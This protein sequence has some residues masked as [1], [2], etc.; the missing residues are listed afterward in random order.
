[1]V[2]VMLRMLTQFKPTLKFP[3]LAEYCLKWLVMRV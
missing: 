3:A 2:V 1:M